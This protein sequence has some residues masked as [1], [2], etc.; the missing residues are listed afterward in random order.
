[1]IVENE[2]KPSKTAKSSCMKIAA[3][4]NHF[5]YFLSKNSANTSTVCNNKVPQ[6]GK[7]TNQDPNTGLKKLKSNSFMPNIGDCM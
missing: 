7:M 1:M 3:K 6:V 2:I 5:Q 4:K